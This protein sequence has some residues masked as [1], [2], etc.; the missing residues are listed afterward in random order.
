[1]GARFWTPIRVHDTSTIQY[2]RLSFRVTKPRAAEPAPEFATRFRVVRVDANG[3]IEALRAHDSTTDHEGFQSPRP[4]DG[5]AWYATG[6]TQTMDYTPTRFAD[7]DVA[8]YIYLAE[9]IE[10]DG[11]NGGTI[12]ASNPPENGYISTVTRCS[13]IVL[14]AN[15]R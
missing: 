11:A 7:V 4:V 15:R 9:I 1:M 8:K 6:V 12:D 5:T 14:L 3:V 2:V 13:N 10:E